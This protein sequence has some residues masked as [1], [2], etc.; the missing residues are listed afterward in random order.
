M[1]KFSKYKKKADTETLNVSQAFS[2][3]STCF[4]QTDFL[5]TRNKKQC[6]PYDL[7]KHIADNSVSV[8]TP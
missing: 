5:K 4:L 3:L 8:S 1:P 6:N 2:L 7:C